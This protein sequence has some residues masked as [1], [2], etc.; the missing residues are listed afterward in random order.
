LL[1]MEIKDLIH[2]TI[3]GMRKVAEEIGLKGNI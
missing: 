1:D 3:M 2:E